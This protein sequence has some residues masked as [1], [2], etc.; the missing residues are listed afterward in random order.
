MTM[1]SSC[2][3][4]FTCSAGIAGNKL[5]AKIASA[6]NKPNQQTL[7]PGRYFAALVFKTGRSIQKVVM[8]LSTL[9]TSFPAFSAT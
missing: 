1:P 7:V 3:A 2:L 5:L 8:S 4:G 6:M 9:G